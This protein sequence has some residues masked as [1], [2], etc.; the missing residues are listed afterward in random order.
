MIFVSSEFCVCDP[1]LEETSTVQYT[2]KATTEEAIEPSTVYTEKNTAHIKSKTTIDVTI[3]SSADLLKELFTDV[4][5]SMNLEMDATTI[6]NYM[7][8][9][10][11]ILTTQLNRGKIM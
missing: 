4:A 7:I 5:S 11:P 1:V 3:T 10:E 9:T 6:N 2:T 8:T